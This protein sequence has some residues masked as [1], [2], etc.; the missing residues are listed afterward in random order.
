MDNERSPE[1]ITTSDLREIL[2]GSVR[3]LRERFVTGPGAKWQ[4][5]YDIERPIAA[6]LCQGA[7]MHYHDR[8]NGIRDF[9]VWFFYPFN[10][11]H[12]LH[13]PVSNGVEL[14]LCEPKVRTTSE[15]F[16]I[17]RT[18]GRCAGTVDPKLRSR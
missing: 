10:E 17:P 16:R 4:E 12:L 9:D 1:P 6:A 7:A 15:H 2:A 3:R 5:F 13:R 14:G 8:V 18:E 11:K